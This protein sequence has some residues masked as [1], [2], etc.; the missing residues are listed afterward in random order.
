MKQ[1]RPDTG[2]DNQRRG[3]AVS[4]RHEENT[5]GIC[6]NHLVWAAIAVVAGARA[7]AGRGH[8]AR[9]ERTGNDR[10]Y[11]R[12]ALGNGT[13]GAA[14][15]DHLQQ[16]GAAGKEHHQF[17]RLC[18][19]GAEFGVRPYGRRRGHRAYRFDPAASPETT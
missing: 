15:H 17:F 14:V 12:E 5:M 4:P 9:I 18:H 13:N 8:G 1:A 11:R 2:P 10:G 6:K 3:R 16:R 7:C 19:Q